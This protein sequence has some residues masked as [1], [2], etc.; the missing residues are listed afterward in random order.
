M[1]DDNCQQHK[2]MTCG[3]CRLM[4]ICLPVALQDDEISKLDKIVKRGHVLHKGDHLYRT[5]DPFSSI[6]AIRSG[7]MKTYRITDDGQEQITGFYFPGEVFGMDGLTKNRYLS[8][9][10]AL[11]STAI[12]EI[13]FAHFRQ[14]TAQLPALQMHF[15]QLMSN[16]ITTDQQF[17]VLLN[18]K[19]AVQR[20]ATL[21]LIISARYAHLHLSA[22]TFRLAMSRT[23][24]GNYLGLS[25]ET[26]SRILTRF[27]KQGL[28]AID[29]RE[30]QIL[31]FDVLRTTANLDH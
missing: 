4:K 27:H 20:I 6:Y 30:M 1:S 5:N 22:S 8:S 31:D 21:L 13:P 28:I 14:L 17:M 16:E 18:K 9:A 15:F 3:Q 26:I 12:C 25:V 7:Y 24:I 11:D 19:T 23:D 2:S 29:Q 10:K